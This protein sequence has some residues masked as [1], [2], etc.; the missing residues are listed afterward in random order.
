MRKLVWVKADGKGSW[1]ERKKMVTTALESGADAVLVNE[2]EEDTVRKLGKIQVISD[3]KSADMSLGA[4]VQYK[5]ITS[6]AEEEEAVKLGSKSAYLIINSTDWK[7]IPLEN[8]IASLQNKCKIIVEVTGVEEARTALETMEVGADG[9][10]VNAG[11]GELKK[12][13]SMVEDLNSE[14]L[15][16]VTVTIK[17]L[18]PVGMGD[19]VCIDTASMLEVGEGMLVGSQSNAMLLVHSESIET[20]Y[21]SSRPFRVNAGAVHAYIRLPDNKTK[22][23]SEIKAG[24]E[25]LAVDYEGNTRKVIVGR[26]KVEK[27]P[28]MLV[29]AELD[30]RNISTLLQNAET[31]LLVK[32]S[33]E[34]VSISKIKAGDKVLAYVED[35]GRHFGMRIEESITEK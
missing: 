27:R 16:L 29:E 12:I 4:D 35:A 11:F 9:V 24:S 14:K 13:R 33:G 30:G 23:L 34:P 26:S 32:E 31:I 19:R 2:G 25:V 6:K 18:K 5:Q 17:G 28:L 8:L 7:I 20:E 15:D 21:V 3:G 10:L 1:D 22:Y